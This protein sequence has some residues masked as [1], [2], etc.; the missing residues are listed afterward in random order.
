MEGGATTVGARGKVHVSLAE[1][2]W[3][4]PSLLHSQ[5]N[6]HFFWEVKSGGKSWGHFGVYCGNA[7]FGQIL[8]ILFWF[9]KMVKSLTLI[10]SS[11]LCTR[12][13]YWAMVYLRTEGCECSNAWIRACIKLSVFLILE[14]FNRISNLMESLLLKTFNLGINVT[15]YCFSPCSCQIF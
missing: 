9:V 14:K 10:K 6:L 11:V 1:L 12:S 15:K 3:E 7:W 2:T 5:E 13:N 8:G 4:V